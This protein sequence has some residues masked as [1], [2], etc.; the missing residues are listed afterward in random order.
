LFYEDLHKSGKIA[1]SP[2]SWICGDLRLENFGSYKGDNR[3]VYFDLNDFDE[4]IRALAA[5]ELARIVTSIFIA[6]EKPGNRQKEITAL[7]KFFLQN[8]SAILNKGRAC[9]I[10]QLTAKGIIGSF[11]DRVAAR[12]EKE[13]LAKSTILKGGRLKL[14]IYNSKLFDIDKKLKIALTNHLTH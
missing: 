2:E 5:W 10:E 6:L 11:L 14:K 13:L 1:A 7:A 3:L 8:S 12:K 4:G 9:Y